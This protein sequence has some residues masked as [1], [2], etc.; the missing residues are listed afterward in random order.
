MIPKVWFTTDIKPGGIPQH[1]DGQAETDW[2][3]EDGLG[4][5]S[6]LQCCT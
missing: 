5:A 2:L 3:G 6:N 1:I 4:C